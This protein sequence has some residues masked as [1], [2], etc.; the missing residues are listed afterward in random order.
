MFARG[1]PPRCRGVLQVAGRLRKPR[2]HLRLSQLWGGVCLGLPPRPVLPGRAWPFKADRARPQVVDARGRGCGH[3]GRRRRDSWLW[4]LVAPGSCYHRPFPSPAPPPGALL[5]GTPS[6][7]T[8]S[9]GPLSLLLPGPCC[10]SGQGPSPLGWY[11]RHLHVPRCRITAP[12]RASVLSGSSPRI[13]SAV[14]SPQPSLV[15]AP[16]GVWAELTLPLFPSS[17]GG[18]RRARLGPPLSA[19]RGP[20][21]ARQQRN[22]RTPCAC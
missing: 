2:P 5:P 12:C 19:P 22:R 4:A 13:A 6:P 15:Q 7:G 16:R 8:P 14:P 1:S 20:W 17:P 18:T 21:M 3:V 10:H 11:G 9:L